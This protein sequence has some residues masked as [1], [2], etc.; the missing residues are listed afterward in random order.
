MSRSFASWTALA[1]FASVVALPCLLA[2]CPDR[3]DPG[4]TAADA[5]AD[6]ATARPAASVVAHCLLSRRSSCG[7]TMSIAHQRK[8]SGV[9]RSAAR[10]ATASGVR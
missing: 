8:L 5:A 3:K 6:V 4:A 9:C 1:S 10:A 2:A 7:A